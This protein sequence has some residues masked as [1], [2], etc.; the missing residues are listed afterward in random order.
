LWLRFY[1]LPRYLILIRLMIMSSMNYLF[2]NYVLL[3]FFKDL[4]IYL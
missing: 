1:K 3:D 2:F 4:K